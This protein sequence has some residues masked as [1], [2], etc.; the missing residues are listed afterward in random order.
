MYAS[1]SKDADLIMKDV[2]DILNQF[3]PYNP[4]DV[5]VLGVLIANTFAN[6]TLVVEDGYPE[7]EK[8]VMSTYR[9]LKEDHR[10]ALKKMEENGELEAYKEALRK[11]RMKHFAEQMK[12]K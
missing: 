7:F 6:V 5:T 10:P 9:M 1:I 11:R 3:D 12:K 4:Y 2:N 8:N